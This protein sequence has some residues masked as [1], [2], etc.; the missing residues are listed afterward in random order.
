[1][2]NPFEIFDQRLSNI[3]N[4]LLDLKHS[5]QS[6]DQ[7]DP[8]PI[9]TTEQAMAFLNLAKPTIYFLTSQGKINSI[10]KGKKLYFLKSDLQNY[11]L[12]GRRKTQPE[13]HAET[14]QFLQSGKGAT[15]GR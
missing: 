13:K 1:M 4:L 8:D 2:T 11:L 12:S 5:K 6:I 14:I 15:N 7:T 3:E 10:K 9:F